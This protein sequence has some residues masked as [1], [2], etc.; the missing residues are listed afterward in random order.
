MNNISQITNGTSQ[1]SKERRRRI[2]N[3]NITGWVMISPPFIGFLCFTAIPMFYGL[4]IS[5]F[6]LNS[7]VLAFKEYVGFSNYI[8]IIKSPMTYQALKNTMFYTVSI[9]LNM[10]LS[11]FL[12]QQLTGH[13]IIGHKLWRIILFLPQVCSMVAVTVMWTW[14]LEPTQGIVNQILPFGWKFE[15][16]VIK[17]HFMPSI[18]LMSLWREGTNVILLQ[19]A[20]VNVNSSLQEAARLDGAN[21]FQVFWKITFQAILPTLFYMLITSFIGA[22]QEMGLFQIMSRGSQGPGGAAV[23]IAYY[24]VRMTSTEVISSGYGMSSALS[25]MFAI[26]LIIVTRFLMWLNDRYVCYD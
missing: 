2:R 4:Y 11:L 7:T 23:T 20:L 8:T 17:S 3:T 6:Y 16:S 25:W 9:F 22:T 19:S 10:S 15:P 1:M 18:L 26:V 21:E 13:E 5:F 12:A 24:I 14:I